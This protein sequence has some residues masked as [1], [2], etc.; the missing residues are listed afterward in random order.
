LAACILTRDDP[1]ALSLEA[2]G[3]EFDATAATIE[4]RTA[5]ARAIG[6]GESVPPDTLRALVLN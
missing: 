6:Y 2:L 3:V 1:T 5:A 4:A